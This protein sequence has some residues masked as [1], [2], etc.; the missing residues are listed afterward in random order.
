[1]PAGHSIIPTLPLNWKETILAI[2]PGVIATLGWTRTDYSPWMLSGTLL[3]LAFIATAYWVNNK[4]F[5]HWSLLAAGLVTAQ[6]LS[7]IEGVIGGLSALIVGATAQV[8]VMMILLVVFIILWTRPPYAPLPQYANTFVVLI[9]ICHLVVRLKYFG[10]FGFSWDVALQ[11]FSISLYAALNTLLLP[12]AIG[13]RLN[14]KF[15]PTSVLFVLGMFYGNFQLLVDVNNIVSN[16]LDNTVWISIYRALIPLFITLGGALC[17]ARASSASRRLGGL[18]TFI[19]AGL[20][21]NFSVVG[22]SY[23]GTLPLIIWLSFIPYTFS[24][25]L[26]F[27]LI[28]GISRTTSTREIFPTPSV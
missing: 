3:L 28:D 22:W 7:F 13:R 24:V 27:I 2:S 1:M 10:L 12:I 21:I 16:Q 25:L 15:G 9:V 19:S 11:W 26:T 17:F 23:Q 6:A 4:Q 18:L 8:S 20:I 5:P 14:P